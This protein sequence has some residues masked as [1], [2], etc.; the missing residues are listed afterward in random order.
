MKKLLAASLLLVSGSALAGSG[1]AGSVSQVPGQYAPK[2]SG[3][4]VQLGAAALNA[5]EFPGMDDTETTAVP[6][7]NVSYNDTFYFEF[8]KLGV[9]LWKPEDTGFRIGLVAQ[10]RKGYDKGDGPIP[11]ND[12]DDTALAGVRAKWKSGKFVIEGSVLGSSESDSGGEAHIQARY[13]FLASQTG[14]LT[15]FV[16]FE[17]LSE[18]AVD[19]FY[20]DERDANIDNATNS[21]VGVIGT[22]NI[23]SKWTILGAVMA[24]SYGDSISDAPGVTEDS[25]TAALLGATYTF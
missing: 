12:V 5:P 8:N 13:T 11:N 9:W 14:T 1:V 23:N 2:Q 17:A 25:G 4:H 18:D 3:W 10:S 24:T 16:R 6:L 20:Y 7:L 21:S 15:G 19:Y 22:Y